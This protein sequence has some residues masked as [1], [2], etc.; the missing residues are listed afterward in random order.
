MASKDVDIEEPDRLDARVAEILHHF[1]RTTRAGQ[2]GMSDGGGPFGFDVTTALLVD[3]LARAYQC[4]AIVETGCFLGDTADYLAR[5]Y[6]NLPITTCDVW[7]PHASFTARRLHRA[8]HV[9]VLCQDSPDVVAASCS[10]YRRPLFFLDAH[11]G[12]GG[13]PLR[14]ELEAITAGIVVIHD[15]DIGHPRFAYDTYDGIVCG[16][17]LL[18]QI[19]LPS[20]Y[21][22]PDPAARFPLPCLQTGRRSGIGI[23]AINVQTKAL[24]AHPWLVAHRLPEPA[25][26]AA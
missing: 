23:L 3:E 21:F 1:Y 26:V 16:P 2:L 22:T 20:L 9:T 14:R 15:F 19:D 25:A 11:G 7:E 4:D 13:W 24:A 5:A 12:A 10:R 17:A 8:T 18:A 6:P